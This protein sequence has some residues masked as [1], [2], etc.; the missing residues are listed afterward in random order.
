MGKRVAHL[1][2]GRM[3]D[4]MEFDDGYALVKTTPPAAIIGQPLS[5]T[6]VRKRFGVTIVAIKR[7]GE[8]FTYASPETVVNRGDV[9]IASGKTHLVEH[10]SDEV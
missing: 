2:A 4:Y 3:L 1:V 5:K 10:F 8:D 6:E 9:I 7:P